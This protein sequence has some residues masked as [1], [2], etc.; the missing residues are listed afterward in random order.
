MLTPLRSQRSWP[1]SLGAPVAAMRHRRNR[2]VRGIGKLALMMTIV[3]LFVG[4]TANGQL[5]N[6]DASVVLQIEELIKIEEDY[7]WGDV[8]DDI[9]GGIPSDVA[10]IDFS[11]VLKA[12]ISTNPSITAPDL[13]HIQLERYEVT[14]TRT[15]GG[16][17]VPPG[18]TSGIAG[19]VRLTEIGATD[20]VVLTVVNVTIV[21]ATIKGQPPISFLIDPG[22]ES[23]T[24]F[25]NIQVNARIQFFGR[26]IAGNEVSVVAN[27][28]IN[29]AQWA[30]PEEESGD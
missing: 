30:D 5:D 27:V 20:P 2:A 29:F 21:P 26:T 19:L 1:T 14:Y 17:S 10:S 25:F 28:G 15:D 6:T 16:T 23:G 4:C 12:P 24:N 9:T 8:Q 7:L 22:T 3:G 11:G 18:F 13:Q